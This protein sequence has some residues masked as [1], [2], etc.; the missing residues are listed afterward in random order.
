MR[1]FKQFAY[2]LFYLIILGVLAFGAYSV[3]FKPASSCFNGT[4]DQGEQ[5]IDCGGVCAKTCT[6]SELATITTG[7]PIIFHPTPSSV[8]VMVEIKN[9]NQNFSARK[10]YYKFT[11]RDDS[12]NPVAGGEISGDSFVYASEIKYVAE[13]NKPFAD[14]AKIVSADFSIVGEPDWVSGSLL[15]KPKLDLQNSSTSASGNEIGVTGSIINSNTVS[16]SQ[17]DIFAII[18]SKLGQP[19]GISKTQ[20]SNIAPGQQQLFSITHPLLGNIDFPATKVYLYG[21]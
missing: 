20:V 11:L 21:R 10:F 9:P 16:V 15:A 8:S 1:T 6:P 14:A 13:F 5:G 7:Q 12:G 19:A 17:V 2:G 3:F 18:Y 4:Q